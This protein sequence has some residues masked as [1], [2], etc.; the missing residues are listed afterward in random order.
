MYTQSERGGNNDDSNYGSFYLD[1]SG[2]GGKTENPGGRTKKKISGR[3]LSE[4]IC[5]VPTLAW[6]RAVHIGALCCNTD[7]LQ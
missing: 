7:S 6:K 1:N 4:T 5:P 2:K 3:I